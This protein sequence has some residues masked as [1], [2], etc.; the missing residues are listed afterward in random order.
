M[1]LQWPPRGGGGAGGISQ[2]ALGGGC[3]SQHA[4]GRGCLP[5]G[6]SAWEGGVWQGGVC[7]G[8]GGV[9]PVHAGIHAPPPPR[10]QNRRRL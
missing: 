2:H 5:R 4:L 1:T 10:E 3:V 8:G 7:Q 9:C 6:V